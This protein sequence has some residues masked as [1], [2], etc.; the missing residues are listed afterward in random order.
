M[1]RN[2]QQP[3]DPY[4][5]SYLRVQQVLMRYPLK[6]AKLYALLSSKTIRSFQLAEPGARR[7][8]RLIDRFSLDEYFD[9]K[10]REAGL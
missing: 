6:R 1:H 5:S 2:M 7:G 10:A 3:T 4:M 8:I 9:T